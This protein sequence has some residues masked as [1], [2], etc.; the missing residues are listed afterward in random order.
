MRVAYEE[1]VSLT[2][3][4]GFLPYIYI[5]GSAWKAGRRIAAFFG[6]AVTIF[7]LVCSIIPTAD[8]HN[9]WLYEGKLAIGTIGMIGS[10]LFLYARRSRSLAPKPSLTP[11][12]S[13]L[14][15]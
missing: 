11:E 7:C 12:P 10:G 9:I 14:T 4:G 13:T 5:F 8:V 1:I 2:F 3:I 15:P 6:F